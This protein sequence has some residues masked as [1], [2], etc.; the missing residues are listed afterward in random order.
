VVRQNREGV[1]VPPIVGILSLIGGI[2]LLLVP[3]RR[4]T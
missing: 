2:V 1:A 4:R 3:T